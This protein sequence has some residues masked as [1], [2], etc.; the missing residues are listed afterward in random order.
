MLI[1]PTE[2]YRTRRIAT[3]TYHACRITTNDHIKLKI[4]CHDSSGCHNS[5]GSYRTTGSDDRSLTNPYII[6]D[7]YRTA[8]AFTLKIYRN[9][10]I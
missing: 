1:F 6:T 4:M 10:R 5:S 2:T 7:P 9:F 3:I 8:R